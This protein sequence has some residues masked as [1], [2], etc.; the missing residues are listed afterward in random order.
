MRIAELAERY[1][2]QQ[3]FGELLAAKCQKAEEDY[4]LKIVEFNQEMMGVKDIKMKNV[5][6]IYAGVLQ[7][8]S[9]LE[10]LNEVLSSG[11]NMFL[12]PFLSHFHKVCIGIETELAEQ[13]LL[14]HSDRHLTELQSKYDVRRAK[15]AQNFD[16]FRKEV[17]TLVKGHY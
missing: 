8:K 6:K 5:D 17:K 15:R 9:G 10:H 13:A 12:K 11:E 2:R 3:E 16:K 7:I 14:P 4:R 1:E